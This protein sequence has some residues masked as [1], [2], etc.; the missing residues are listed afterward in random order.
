MEPTQPE[1]QVPDT[2]I[3]AQRTTI[4]GAASLILLAAANFQPLADALLPLLPEQARPWLTALGSLLAF[5][6]VLFAR[7][8]AGQSFA[9]AQAGTQALREEVRADVA[10]AKDVA[11]TAAARIGVPAGDGTQFNPSTRFPR[12]GDGR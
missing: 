11:E 12:Q 2:P 4:A 5:A 10:E 9:A 8:A 6:S 3:L 7:N 1:P